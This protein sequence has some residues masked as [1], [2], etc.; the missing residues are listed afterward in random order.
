M[1]NRRKERNIIT[2][3]LW[4]L[5]CTLGTGLNLSM[6]TC[7]GIKA[8]RSFPSP[9]PDFIY[10]ISFQES[11]WK[12]K[13]DKIDELIVKKELPPFLI[14]DPENSFEKCEK[15][16][17]NYG[18]KLIVKWPGMI[19][20][21]DSFNTENIADCTLEKCY[22][23]SDINNWLRTAEQNLFKGKRF[24]AAYRHL[25]KIDNINLFSLKSNGHTIGTALVHLNNESAGIYMVSVNSDNRKKGL[26]TWLMKK[27][28]T[29]IY[30]LKVQ[31]VVLQANEMS[32]Q[33]YQ[34]IGFHSV[35]DFEI[36]W[37]IGLI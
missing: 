10:N 4:D 5:Y 28:I 11:D 33:M 23:D 26:G 35:G 16:L 19:M 36:Y 30:N 3:N 37:K 31:F 27:I 8:I 9:W 18:F 14:T 32:T 29:E 2:H 24:S 34:K 25:L 6:L 1:Q 21:T 7:Y 13:I 15:M 22:T 20:Q 17:G 12:M